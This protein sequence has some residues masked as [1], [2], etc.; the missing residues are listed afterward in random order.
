M[1]ISFSCPEC[2]VPLNVPDDFGGKRSKCPQCHARVMIPKESVKSSSKSKGKSKPEVHA[3]V[4]DNGDPFAF[5]GGGQL[6]S[7][8]GHI[9]L[10]DAPGLSPEDEPLQIDPRSDEATSWRTVAKGLNNVWLGTCL[11]A[12]G[13]TTV[14][15][16]AGLIFFTG[17]QFVA[18]VAEAA[19]N[20]QGAAAQ[21]RK[22]IILI[23]NLVVAGLI[24]L[25][26]G[27]GSLLRLFGFIR[28]LWI[29]EGTTN[30]L[31]ALLCLPA[32]LTL[33]GGM[34]LIGVGSLLFS[35]TM[36]GLGLAAFLLG[37]F[38]GMLFL[39]LYLRGVGR[40]MRSKLLP[41]QAMRYFLWLFLGIAYL[42]ATFGGFA[43]TV[44][45]GEGRS[46]GMGSMLFLAGYGGSFL[47]F[48]VWLM[49]Y[50]GVLTQ[51][52]D[53]IRKRVGKA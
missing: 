1:T 16:V 48:L 18:L 9:D 32:E 29:P 49:K 7:T 15:L 14:M 25:F 26:V 53:D 31:L 43:L 33:I 12:L 47:V 11:I 37:T 4:E 27:F 46:G 52:M 24:L 28:T 30:W 41:G 34:A 19:E 39:M 17:A 6:V 36:T 45:F 8:A 38:P 10:S 5:A 21:A 35:G 40:A 3:Q 13:L 2:K 22:P 44:Y 23:A 42:L 51:G 50:L 20:E